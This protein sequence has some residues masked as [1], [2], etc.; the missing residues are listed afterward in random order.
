MNSLLIKNISRLI[1]MES[2]A[3]RKGPLGVI[4][5]ACVLIEAGKISWLGKLEQLN[6][7]DRKKY[8]ELDAKEAVVTPGL[9]ECHTHLVHAGSRHSEFKQRCEGVSYWEITNQGGGIM[10]TVRATRQAQEQE[11]F[12]SAFERGNQALKNGITTLEIKSGYGLDEATE[13]KILK[14]IQK[15]NTEH[16]LDFYP[17]FL[18]AHVVPPEYK[19]QPED[20]VNLVCEQMLPQIAQQGLAKACDVFVE[21]GAFSIEQGF[22]ICTVA[23]SYGLDIRLHVD[24]FEDSRGA[25]LAAELEA[26]AA[27]HL[28]YVCKKGIE[29]MKASGVVAVVLPGATFF[30]GNKEYAPARQMIERGVTVAIST[31][32]NPGTN[33]CLN[34]ILTGTIAATQMQLTL[35]EVW[36]GITINAAKALGLEEE[37]GS[38][39][40]GKKADLTFFDSPDEYYPFYC[41]DQNL[42]KMVIKNG[43][44]AYNS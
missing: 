20:Y 34:L 17:T 3:G 18:G 25:L 32:Y 5:D 15:L 14:V 28:E 10:S 1:T 35:D 13:L 19:D 27:D 8:Q 29:A 38:I 39:A 30:V 7:K 42:V 36:A 40:I 41:Y 43:K 11:L 16:C 26:K 23:K 44:I 6:L 4:E 33:S 2:G 12:E 37:I 22:K 21:K 24:Q 9:V 31:D